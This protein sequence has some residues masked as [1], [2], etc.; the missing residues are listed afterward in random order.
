MICKAENKKSRMNLGIKN[1]EFR[2][3]DNLNH[4]AWIVINCRWAA[5]FSK[6]TGKLVYLCFTEAFQDDFSIRLF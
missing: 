4:D 5:V 3:Y 6:D 1:N 2:I